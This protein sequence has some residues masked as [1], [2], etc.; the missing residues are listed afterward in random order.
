M[1]VLCTCT[2]H[3]IRTP[4]M[5]AAM[6]TTPA[7]KTALAKSS[8]QS[9]TCPLSRSRSAV[10]STCLL[11]HSGKACV[12]NVFPPT[13]RR[14]GSLPPTHT[15]RCPKHVQA[16]QPPPKAPRRPQP[17]LARASKHPLGQVAASPPH[18]ARSLAPRPCWPHL[19]HGPRISE[20]VTFGAGNFLAELRLA[21]AKAGRP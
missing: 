19:S 10:L 11:H 1:I 5:R 15:G 17:H 12:K 9:T 20:C 14:S 16:L 2:P 4:P 6:P 7:P 8:H 13:G 18:Q 3:R 21:M